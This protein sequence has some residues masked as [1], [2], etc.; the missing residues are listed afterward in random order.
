MDVESELQDELARNDIRNFRSANWEVVPYPLVPGFV[1]RRFAGQGS[2]LSK[3]HIE[4]EEKAITKHVHETGEIEEATDQTAESVSS[5]LEAGVSP[6][7]FFELLGPAEIE[8]VVLLYLQTGTDS[9]AVIKSTTSSS[10]ATIECELRRINDGSIE[11]AFLQVKSGDATISP[12]SYEEK[13]DY[14][15]VFFFAQSEVSVEERDNMSVITEDDILTF[16]REQTGL[17]P[18]AVLRKL[19]AYL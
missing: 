18:D 4:P 10:E 8:D 11:R 2:T 13:A 19:D 14:G 16:A 9:W 1:K 5:K 3:M 6:K 12:E 15:H 17:L 7:R